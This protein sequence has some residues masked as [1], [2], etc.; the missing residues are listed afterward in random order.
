MKIKKVITKQDH[1]IVLSNIAVTVFHYD[2]NHN[3][4]NK[5]PIKHERFDK[6]FKECL[7]Q[8][9]SKGGFMIPFPG[10]LLDK[11]ENLNLFHYNCSAKRIEIYRYK[12]DGTFIDI[13]RLPDE[14]RGAF[15][16]D[17]RGRIYSD[18]DV[19]IVGIY[20]IQNND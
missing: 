4:I 3:L 18:I 2:E 5:F 17:Q 9:V 20:C 19:D 8:A 6:D 11:E 15:C 12:I 13:N 10:F 16:I 7:G 14:T 1:V